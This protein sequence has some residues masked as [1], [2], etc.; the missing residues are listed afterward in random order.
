MY[1]EHVAQSLL[2]FDK[3]EYLFA[4]LV[5]MEIQAEHEKVSTQ[6]KKNREKLDYISCS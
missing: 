5:F 1:E 4:L 2:L 6:E 3:H